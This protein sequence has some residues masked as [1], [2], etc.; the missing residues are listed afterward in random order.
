MEMRKVMSSIGNA[1]LP[2]TTGR[3]DDDRVKHTNGD[4]FRR[5]MI[6]SPSLSFRCSPTSVVT[7]L[8]ALPPHPLPL[9][10]PLP[11]EAVEATV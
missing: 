8:S 1:V 5:A 6:L 7:S 11:A 2:T 10:L 4:T 3:H 9:P